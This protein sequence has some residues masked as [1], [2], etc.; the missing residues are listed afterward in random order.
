[1][2]CAQALAVALAA[3]VVA[4]EPLRAPLA[5]AETAIQASA[6]ETQ[7]MSRRAI[8]TAVEDLAAMMERR[9]VLPE[10]GAAYARTLRADL[11]AGAYDGKTQAELAAALQARLTSVHPDGHLRVN[12]INEEAPPE[13]Q[14][15]SGDGAFGEGA[16][17]RDGVAYLPIRVFPGDE[18]SQAGMAALL[19][20]Y[21]G[22]QALIL[23]LRTCYGGAMPVMDV[24]F[25]R[26]YATRT[27]LITMDFREGAA[28]E[29]EEWLAAMPSTT[30]DTSPAGLSRWQHWAV[31]APGGATLAN[32]RVFVLTGRTISA[33][34]HAALAL[35]RTGRA[36]LIGERT[37]G[38]GNYG[39][40]ERF[41]GDFEV[42]VSVGRSFNPD[43]G[44]GWEGTGL[45]PDM[46]TARA[47]A[48]DV[49]MQ[50][51]EGSRRADLAPVPDGW[52]HTGA[53]PPV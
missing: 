3:V 36:T 26:L 1:M 13:R 42:W 33:C 6:A 7:A 23:D 17:F 22:A 49:A 41:G 15:P 28:P 44:E 40:M 24:L 35:Q 47:Q 20:S 29:M 4:G 45:E 50:Q 51:I 39:G 19:D 31:P 37:F 9:Y 34:E 30:K 11:R 14:A 2:N 21:A 48:L 12:V 32:A 27:Q 8:R 25:S 52:I 5:Q 18:E 43:T 10:Q 46:T 38:A 53:R 16:W